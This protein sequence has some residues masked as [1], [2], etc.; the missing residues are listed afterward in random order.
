MN[1]G[2]HGEEPARAPELDEEER[3]RIDGAVQGRDRRRAIPWLRRMLQSEDRELRQYACISLGR[4]EGKQAMRLLTD[5]LFNDPSVRVREQ[6]AHALSFTF[7]DGIYDTM[8]RVPADQ[9]EHEAVRAQAAEGLANILG[10]CDRRTRRFRR[11]QEL[12]IECLCE[13]SPEVRFWSAFALGEMH[14]T[15]AL[16]E[17]QRLAETDHVKCRNWWLVSEEAADCIERI[18][19]R[20]PA[21]RTFEWDGEVEEE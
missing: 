8:M 6:A 15:R 21:D 2:E 11:A 16:P 19:G 1:H 10:Y 3:R 4:L 18:H 14:S 17:L 9:S 20:C 5:T 12:L 7:D 13:P